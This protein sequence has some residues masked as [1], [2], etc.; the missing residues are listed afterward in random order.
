M[1]GAFFER[2]NS[3]PFDLLVRSERLYVHAERIRNRRRF[4]RELLGSHRLDMRLAER[5]PDLAPGP[6][7]MS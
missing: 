2:T 6:R 7:N 3:L 1:A 5:L 4:I